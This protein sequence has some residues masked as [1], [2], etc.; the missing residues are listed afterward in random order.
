MDERI[1][2]Y[3]EKAAIS[4]SFPFPRFIASHWVA[5]NGWSFP[6]DN[7]VGNI[8]YSGTGN[9]DPIGV[10]AGVSSV[11]ENKVVT[12]A[13][14]ADGVNAYCLLLNLP[15]QNKELDIDTQSL[16]DCAGDVRKMC[17]VV[18]DSN[19][20]A[21]H[22]NP[23]NGG[24]NG[25]DIFNVYNSPE[26]ESL[27]SY[28]STA[29]THPEMH[30][31]SKNFRVYTVEKGDTLYAISRRFLVPIA[32]LVR[33]NNIANPDQIMAGQALN[34]PDR[35]TVKPG[36]TLSLIAKE[37]NQTVEELAKINGIENVNRIYVREILYI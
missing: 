34:I 13:T 23:G 19:W 4:M 36:D 3:A 26:M 7:N 15:I 12:Y 1:R 5:E 30:P 33:L 14:P 29:P 6:T 37:T 18:G 10:F 8:S 24:W 11:Q 28:V 21:S 22:Y 31:P 9:P 20:A 27:F 35:Y 17:E 2:E 25:E 16:R 32:V